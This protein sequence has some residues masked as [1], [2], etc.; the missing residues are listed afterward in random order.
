MGKSVVMTPARLEA[1]DAALEIAERAHAVLIHT[2]ADLIEALGIDDAQLA[3]IAVN[4][5]CNPNVTRASALRLL[6]G[7]DWGAV[8]GWQDA[9]PEDQTAP[10]PVLQ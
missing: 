9:D 7:E 6:A 2:C 3:D 10:R 5:V 1:L 4:L 8:M